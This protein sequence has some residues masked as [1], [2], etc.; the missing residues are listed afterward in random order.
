[1]L[2]VLGALAGCSGGGN[3]PGVSAAPASASVP[4]SAPSPEPPASASL[5]YSLTITPPV[6]GTISGAASGT[7]YPSGTAVNLT[8]STDGTYGVKEWTGDARPCGSSATCQVT[9]SAD[10]T[11]GVEFKTV[12]VGFGAGTTGGEGGTV[13]TVSSPAELKA[14]LCDS[15]SGGNCT[16]TT[17]RIIQIASA[18][19]FRSTEGTRTSKGCTYSNNSCSVNGK[20]EQILDVAAYCSGKTT[21]DITFDA[22]GTSPLRVGSNKTL[23]GIGADSA[24]KGKGLMLSGGVSNIVIRNLSVTDINDGVIW[25][26]DAITIDNASRIWIDHNHIARIGRQMIV[27]GWGTAANVTISNNFLDGTTDYGHFCDGRHYWTMLLVGE[28]QS[29]TLIGNKIY[30]TAGRAPELGKQST[31]SSGGTVHLVNNLYDQNYYMGI[32]TSD[33]VLSFI[34]GNYFTPRGLYF[35]PIFRDAGSNNLIYAPLD[36]TVDRANIDCLA[37]LGRNCSSNYTTTSLPDFTLNADVM[38]KIEASAA[39][40]TAIGSVRP[41]DNGKVPSRID[42]HAGPQLDPDN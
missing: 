40:R 38:P 41:F 8:A 20:K 23:I 19:D 29:I 7:S 13:V 12:P 21:Y 25:A 30:N 16:D 37:N 14:A 26:G 31:A 9:M 39:L 3:A 32:R 27:T 22:A 24:I 4:A 6:N 1:M 5:S 10:L 35:S 17:P 42:G 33:D 18:I 34:E 15:M 11:V 2:I 28:N 36:A